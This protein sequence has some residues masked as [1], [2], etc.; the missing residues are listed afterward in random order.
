MGLLFGR[1]TLVQALHRFFGRAPYQLP[2]VSHSFLPVELPNLQIALEQYEQAHL[3]QMRVIGY[4]GSIMGF[5][6]SLAKLAGQKS[7]MMSS[8]LGMKIGPV[9]YR[10]VDVDVDQQMSCVERGIFL[11][12]TDRGNFAAHVRRDAMF[13]RGALE[14]EV[15]SP[16]EDLA[17]GF[18]G[19]FAGGRTSRASTAAKSFPCAAAA[20]RSPSIGFQPSLATRS[21]CRK[22]Q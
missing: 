4:T 8:F 11:I 19:R 22:R 15:M 17:A 2:V 5:Q 16:D 12:K 13:H 9:Q 20:S 7:V 14:L 3:A 10:M 6:D 18:L 21:S 1:R